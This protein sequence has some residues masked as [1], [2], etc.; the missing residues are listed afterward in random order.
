MGVL[1]WVLGYFGVAGGIRRGW[2]LIL[3]SGG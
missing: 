1:H 3:G 2:D